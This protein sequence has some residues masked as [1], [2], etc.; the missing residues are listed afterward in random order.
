MIRF[1]DLIFSIIGLILCI[2]LFLIIALWIKFDSK[3]SIFYKQTRVG[4]HGIDFSLLKFR[5]MY[6]DSDKKG[7]ITIGNHDPRI[8][9][10][11]QFIRKYKIDELPQLMNVLKGDMSFVGPRPEVRK[12][13][14]L[15]TED[16]KLILSNRPG[17]TDFASIKFKNENELLAKTSNPEEY[18]IQH[19]I[20][21]KIKLNMIFINNHSVFNYLKIIII[22]IFKNK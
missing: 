3:G 20:N 4:R 9:R 11:G 2:P 15:Y 1:L 21:E 13:V 8:T 22:T 6:L 12:Y 14:N 18:Y 16:Q 17:I 10:S 7:L 5:S 19:I